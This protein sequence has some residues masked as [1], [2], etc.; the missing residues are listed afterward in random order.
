MLS[1]ALSLILTPKVRKPVFRRKIMNTGLIFAFWYARTG[2]CCKKNSSGI[3]IFSQF[4]QKNSL[5]SSKW[6]Q[7]ARRLTL[8]LAEFTDITKMKGLFAVFV[9]Y[10]WKFKSI[11]SF[12]CITWVLKINLFNVSRILKFK[13]RNHLIVLNRKYI[14]QNNFKMIVLLKNSMLS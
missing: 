4:G 14:F 6:R 11:A 10:I 3:W 9:I 5:S 2:P 8:D 12:W 13:S 7:M 1:F